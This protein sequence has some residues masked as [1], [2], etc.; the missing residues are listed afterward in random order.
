ML[1]KPFVAIQGFYGAGNVGDEAILGASIDAIRGCGK[2]A[3][4][5]AWNPSVVRSEWGVPATGIRRRRD[6]PIQWALAR[7]NALVVG[8]GGLLKDYGS[9]PKGVE[10]WLRW[11]EYGSRLGIP[12]MTWSIGV[13]S[14]EHSDSVARVRNVL[15]RIDAITVRDEGSAS[16]LREMG[17]T[18]DVYVTADPVPAYVRRYRRARD[19][20]GRRVGVCVRHWFETASEIEDPVVFSSF[21]GELARGLDQLIEREGAEVHFLPFRTVQGDD[22]RAIA[23]AVAKRMRHPAALVDGANPS[24]D[25]TINRL[26]EVDLVVAMRLHATIIGTTLGVPTLAL[27]YD[28][29][30]TDFMREIGQEDYVAPLQNIR[31]GWI[32]ERA[33]QAWRDPALNAELEGATDTLAERFEINTDLLR[34]RLNVGGSK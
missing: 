12:T 13:G 1:R 27:S 30:V 15:N 21:L 33:S 10:K 26:A 17:V 22:D 34:Q 23:E 6:E 11:L 24:V 18:N 20:R 32:V 31:G 29:K 14:F 16:R 4:V 28:A 8:G 9:G 3:Y 25:E 19:G 7:S 5:L 2:E